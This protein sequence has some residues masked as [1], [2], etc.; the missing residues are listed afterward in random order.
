MRGKENGDGRKNGCTYPG[1][2][3]V[4]WLERRR[5]YF[6]RAG[7]GR[8]LSD[9]PHR[10]LAAARVIEKLIIERTNDLCGPSA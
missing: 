6:C 5:L 4:G 2:G 1:G 8:F 10:H 7:H 3:R 9:N